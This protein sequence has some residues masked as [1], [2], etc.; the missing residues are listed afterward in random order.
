M[1]VKKIDVLR[2]N[3][4]KVFQR[5]KV[6]QS[7]S[8][9]TIWLSPFWKT[10]IYFVHYQLQLHVQDGTGW[11]RSLHFNKVLIAYLNKGRETRAT[12]PD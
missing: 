10:Q 2:S 12:R 11:Y 6:S 3:T 8:E 7:D 9:G 5:L 4:Y 1:I